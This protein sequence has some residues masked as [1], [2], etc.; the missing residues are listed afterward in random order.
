MQHNNQTP[1]PTPSPLCASFAPRLALLGSDSLD[2]QTTA[3][4]RAHLAT[5]AWCRAKFANFE[6]VDAALVRAFGA[7]RQ[8]HPQGMLGLLTDF[9]DDEPTE[10]DLWA[11]PSQRPPRRRPTSTLLAIACTIALVVAAGAIFSALP[12]GS[13]ASSSPVRTVTSQPSV[14][15]TV[16]PTATPLSACGLLTGAGTPFQSLSLVPG[17]VL[18]SGTY[19]SAASDT[20]GGTGRYSVH[21]YTVCYPGAEAAV[22][23]DVLSPH[24]TPTSSLSLLEQSGWTAGE[25]FP[26][27]G[28]FSLLD[29]C[30]GFRYCLNDAGTPAPFTFLAVDQ[31]FT[32]AGGLTT[33][34]LQVATIPAPRCLNN[35]AYYSG[36]PRYTLYEGET[37][38]LTPPTISSCRQR[39][40]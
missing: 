17:L 21:S 27:D 33:F 4:T 15:P 18:P 23:G 9:G 2:P 28:D 19:I 1:T 7:D 35:P 3:A 13:G 25:L 30:T 22:D 14:P 11:E 26:S 10:S 20:G 16:A 6:I 24:G 8:V 38:R 5:C 12:R 32:R 36:T 37:R 29:H 31:F 34:R 40:G 39:R